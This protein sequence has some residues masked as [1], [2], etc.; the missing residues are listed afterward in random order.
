[1]RKV[2]ILMLLF[3][4]GCQTTLKPKLQ[5]KFGVTSLKHIEMLSRVLSNRYDGE[6]LRSLQADKEYQ[7]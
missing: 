1:M 3:V 4:V 6:M 7:K 5:P 2:F